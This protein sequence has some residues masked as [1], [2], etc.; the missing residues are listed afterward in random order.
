ME[1]TS[2]KARR[3][4]WYLADMHPTAIQE[5]IL[6]DTLGKLGLSVQ[7]T[8]QRMMGGHGISLKG[9]LFAH[10][11][12]EGTGLRLSPD[13]QAALLAVPG[14][15][16]LIFPGD[17]S[18][19]AKFVLV[20]ESMLDKPAQLAPWVRKAVG[21]SSTGS[22]RPQPNRRPHQKSSKKK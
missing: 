3:G 7:I 22:G 13:D 4:R 5:E 18:R 21:F 8:S 10:L 11:C 17:P 9:H 6:R 2:A 1:H 16:A 19:S 12:A 14:A 15:K 20:P